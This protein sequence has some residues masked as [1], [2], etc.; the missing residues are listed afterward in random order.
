MGA[1]G[2]VYLS[3]PKAPTETL[4]NLILECAEILE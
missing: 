3:R 4:F 2:S 1:A